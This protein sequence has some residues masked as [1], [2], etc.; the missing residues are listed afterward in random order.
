MNSCGVAAIQM[1]L[2]LKDSKSNFSKA[3]I[4][5]KEAVKQGAKLIVLPES[6]N[7]GHFYSSDHHEYAETIEGYTTQQMKILSKDLDIFVAFGINEKTDDQ[8]YSSVIFVGKGQVLGKYHKQ[9]P[10][11]CENLYWNVG[12]GP[13]VIPTPWGRVGFAICWDMSFSYTVA[14]YFDNIDILLISSAW[15]AINMRKTTFE[16]NSILPRAIAMQLR[17]PVVYANL[18]GETVL[19]IAKSEGGISFY[20]TYFLGGS[21]I[22]DHNG[23]IISKLDS[24]EGVVAGTINFFHAQILRKQTIDKVEIKR[25]ISHKDCQKMMV[26]GNGISIA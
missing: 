6:I 4:L 18:V 7:Q 3:R 11:V 12:E 21:M 16:H 8:Y 24:G 26:N 22:C 15:P 13:V 1:Q 25:I 2:Y 17:V 5:I 9:N 14:S 23:S 20:K 19:P 10:A